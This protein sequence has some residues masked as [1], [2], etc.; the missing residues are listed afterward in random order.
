[1]ARSRQQIAEDNGFS[2]YYQYAKFRKKAR[3]RHWKPQTYKRNLRAHRLGFSS[4]YQQRKFNRTHFTKG[5]RGK[6]YEELLARIRARKGGDQLMQN[7]RGVLERAKEF[8]NTNRAREWM[9]RHYYRMI[10]ELRNL[11]V[12]VDNILR[13]ELG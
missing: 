7:F 3:D 6:Q 1:M 13:D 10:Q 9:E 4:P 11:G 5:L 12:P 8:H 2:T